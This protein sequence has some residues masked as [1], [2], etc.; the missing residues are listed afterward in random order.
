[1]NFSSPTKR[2]YVLHVFT[3]GW[4]AILCK[5][6]PE[7]SYATLLSFAKTMLALKVQ[8]VLGMGA[9]RQLWQAAGEKNIL[10]RLPLSIL[11]KFCHLCWDFLKSLACLWE[12]VKITQYYEC[13]HHWEINRCYPTPP[14]VT[15]F[16]LK[17]KKNTNNQFQF[18]HISYCG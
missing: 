11:I 12:R 4:T 15:L 9:N 6:N 2:I 7:R 17:W 14:P 13:L 5:W 16:L 8:R 1:M 18:S 3:W 10:Q